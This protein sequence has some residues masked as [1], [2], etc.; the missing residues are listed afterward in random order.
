V[1]VD[2]K[3]WDVVHKTGG[4]VQKIV[5]NNRKKLSWIDRSIIIK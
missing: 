5:T 1:L 2:D 3:A 4:L